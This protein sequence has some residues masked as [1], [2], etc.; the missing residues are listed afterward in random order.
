DL[1]GTKGMSWTLQAPGEFDKIKLNPQQR[2][3]L[4]L[5][6]KEAINNSSRH[7]DCNSV[8]L[9]LSIIH[10]QI[11]AEIRDD[12]RGMVIT[13]SRQPPG[14][15]RRGRGLENIRRGEA[16]LGGNITI[17]SSPGEGTSVRVEVPQKRVME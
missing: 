9:S 17:N 1:L 10:N 3:H 14:E 6:F 13:S 16:K 5:I 8:W 12:G 4:F 2:R 11:I 7:A 15:D